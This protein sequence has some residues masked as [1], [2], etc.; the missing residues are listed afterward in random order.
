MADNLTP[1]PVKT[2]TAG[3]VKVDLAEYGDSAVGASN[4]IHVQPGTGVNINTQDV[5]QGTAANLNA[6]VQGDAAHDAA[7]SGNPVL[8]GAYAK[9][10]APADVSADG[11]AVRLWA[12]LAGRLQIGDGGGTLSIDDGG[13]AITVD[14]T[15]AVSGTVT[16]DSELPAAA[17]LADNAA[18]PTAPAIGAFNMVWDGATWD[19][20]PG[21]AADGLLVNLGANNDVTFSPTAPTTP[22]MDPKTSAALAAGGSV[23]LDSTDVGAA[24]K[25]LTQLIIT[26]SVPF[27]AELKTV[28]N[29]VATT[30]AYFFGQAND[31]VIWQS[32]HKDYVSQAPAGA[33]FDGFRVSF[34]NMDNSD[35]ADVYATFV[36]EE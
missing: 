36:S 2:K 28:A 20:A 1:L 7:V 8:L 3:D 10:T 23:D 12:D 5:R 9:T 22:L 27:R 19:R 18:N 14:G 17:A 16:V 6:E 35:A 34:K 11:D 24:T 25:K 30:R 32:P 26:A 29:A 21:T 33:G 31:T 4:A 13:G 15:V